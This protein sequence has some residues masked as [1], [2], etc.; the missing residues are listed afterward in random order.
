MTG[1]PDWRRRRW[2]ATHERILEAALALFDAE[3]YDQV[4][5]GRI[6][7]AAGVSVPTFY[8][9]YPSKD[10]LVMRLLAP[11]EVAEL[12]ARQ[13]AELSLGPRI[14]SA[15]MDLVSGVG[16]EERSR[17]YARWRVVAGNPTLRHR[18]GEFERK[19]AIMVAEASARDG[20]IRPADVVVAGAHLAA[21]TTGLLLWA[22]SGGDR[23][24]EDCLVEAF[25]ALA[26]T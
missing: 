18:S 11:E 8:A 6:A 23:E 13:P 5:I 21:F 4:P 15:A 24:L 2:E 16:A 7:A 25:D 3:G 22:D 9:H 14:R 1:S 10:H 12:I 26:E 19:T 17:L 20:K